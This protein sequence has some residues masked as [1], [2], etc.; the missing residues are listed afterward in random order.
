MLPFLKM[1]LQLRENMLEWRGSPMF[2]LDLLNL[3]PSS[4]KQTARDGLVD[5]V[6]D[7]A[8]FAA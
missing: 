5:F 8:T 7:Q 6:A 3:I 1:G 2:Q 4:L